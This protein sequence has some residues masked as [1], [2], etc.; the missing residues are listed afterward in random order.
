[1]TDLTAHSARAVPRIEVPTLVLL[2][3]TCAVWA[4]V[5]IAAPLLGPWLTIGLLAVT[6]AQHSSLQHE[7]IHGHPFTSQAVN[8]VLVFPAPGLFLPYERFREQ[9]LAHHHDPALTD[10]YDDPETN[11]LDPAVWARLSGPARAL[12]SVNNTLLGRMVL[13]PAIGTLLFWRAEVRL[14]ARGEPRVVRAWALHLAGIAPVILWLATVAQVTAWQYLAACWLGLSLL[15]IRTFAEHRAHER[16]G[17]RSVVIEDR[18]PLA[19]LF[20]NNNF[21]AVHHAHPKLPWYRLP[22]EYERRRDTYLRRNGGYRYRS[23][24]ELF[25]RHLLRRKDPV[26]HPLWTPPGP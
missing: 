19:L 9:H 13:G 15:R 10:P 7:A 26:P 12:L 22:D 14:L 23:Y 2:C 21:H 8:D 3:V 18:G 5:T 11:Y 17:A 1:M 4:G 16:H 6:I 24:F 20:L 25:A